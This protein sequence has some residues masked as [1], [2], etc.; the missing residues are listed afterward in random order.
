MVGGWSPWSQQTTCWWASHPFSVINTYCSCCHWLRW[1]LFTSK[2][3]TWSTFQMNH[4]SVG[5]DP[6][7][8]WMSGLIFYR[9]KRRVLGPQIMVYNVGKTIANHPFGN[10]LY[11]HIPPIYGDLED[12]L[13]LFYPHYTKSTFWYAMPIS[14]ST[15]LVSDSLLKG[16]QGLS[17]WNLRFCVLKQYSNV[18]V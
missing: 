11:H 3:N 10:G 5:P 2:L 7:T 6:F 8:P 17:S 4:P 16:L 18:T 14:P 13:L 1:K 9:T 15:W 12:G